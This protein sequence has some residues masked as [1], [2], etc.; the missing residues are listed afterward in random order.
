[1]TAPWMSWQRRRHRL[2]DGPICVLRP[3]T[4]RPACLEPSL[5]DFAQ[6]SVA[7]LVALDDFARRLIDYD[8][9]VVLVQYFHCFGY[10][11]VAVCFCVTFYSGR[12]VPGLQRYSFPTDF[13]QSKILARA[14]RTN[15][16]LYSGREAASGAVGIRWRCREKCVSLCVHSETIKI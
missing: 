2:R 14:Y 9:M 7:R 10:A 15:D 11:S 1:M 4:L 13:R 8:Y 16:V 6:R 12:A 5:D 3:K